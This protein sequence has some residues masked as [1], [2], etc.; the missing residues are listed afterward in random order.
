ML[1]IASLPGTRL[2]CKIEDLFSHTC[3]IIYTNVYTVKYI[4]IS[5]ELSECQ[6][7]VDGGMEIKGSDE[8]AAKDDSIKKQGE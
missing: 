1:P 2:S 8:T 7:N 4:Y 5:K 3:N 6:D